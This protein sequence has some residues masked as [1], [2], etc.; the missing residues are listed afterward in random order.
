[1][2]RGSLSPIASRDWNRATARHLLSRAGFGVSDWREN[3]LLRLGPEKA[4]DR[5]VNYH[6]IA[7][8]LAEPDFISPP[9]SPQQVRAQMQGL[10]EEER[11][12]LR[13]QWQQEQRQAVE[14][15]K[16]WWLDRMLATPRPLE[17]KMALFW[18][19]H[20]ATS[21]QKVRAAW[22]NYQLNKT[23]RELATGNLKALTLAVG[24]SPAMLEYLD[25]NRNVKAH[26]NENWARELMEL[27]TLG[28]GHYS[29]ED[30][31]ASARAFTGWSADHVQFVY[32]TNA[33]DFGAKTFLGKT[34]D[35][36]GWNIIDIIF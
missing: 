6:A 32:R 21:A 35:W 11:R 14:R 36:D 7:D 28:R 25:N 29:E 34:G 22:N 8:Q 19:G 27:F 16:I 4:V 15:L 3:E 18:H 9:P 20:F 26:P 5:L 23:F 33:H 10:S 2:S 31:K 1:M 12:K 17:E 13:N 30:I 24:Q